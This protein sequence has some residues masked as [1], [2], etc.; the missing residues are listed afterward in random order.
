MVEI[1]A[2]E[3]PAAVQELADWGCEFARTEDGRLDQRFFGAHR[4]R[5][6]CFA[7]DFTGR[8]ILGTVA[9]RGAELGI[10]VEE[11]QYVSRLLVADGDLLR[12]ARLRP[13]NRRADRLPRRCGDP[14]DRRP[15]PDLAPQLLAPGRELRR[16][17]RLALDG[18]AAG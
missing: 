1:L 11:D 3:S 9:R 12:G 15:H 16:G 18:R 4:W 10:R 2:R 7:G 6:T 13:A 17:L 14:G 5:R 8:A